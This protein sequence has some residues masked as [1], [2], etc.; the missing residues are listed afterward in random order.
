MSTQR[1]GS[2]ELSD[3]IDNYDSYIVV[4][5]ALREFLVARVAEPMELLPTTIVD[6]E[7]NV[8]STD[9][10]ILN[11]LTFHDAIDLEQ[12]DVR[13]NSIDPEKISRFRKFV[14]APDNI[15]DDCQMLRLKYFPNRLLL[16]R[17]LA[18]AIQTEGFTGVHFAEVEGF[19]R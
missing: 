13:W 7:G 11:L 19:K 9:Y 12:S 17:E 3:A 15:P 8:A 1:K 10:T 4:S 14:L 2:R 5:P 16:R 18:E 6:H